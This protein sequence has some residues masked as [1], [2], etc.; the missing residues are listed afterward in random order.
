LSTPASVGSG[1][2]STRKR[3][4]SVSA[5]LKKLTTT[6]KTMGRR[7]KEAN[8]REKNPVDQPNGKAIRG[9]SS[10]ITPIS[11]QHIG[12]GNVV[13]ATMHRWISNEK[14]ITVR[15]LLIRQ[16]CSPVFYACGVVR[17]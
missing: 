7:D 13:Q 3:S 17:L 2:G 15:L 6:I 11:F 9:I 5:G 14:S 4:S 12:D 8:C 1:K 16:I 10:R